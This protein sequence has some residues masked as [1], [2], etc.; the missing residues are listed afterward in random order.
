MNQNQARSLGASGIAG[1]LAVIIVWILS[2]VGIQVPADV[3]AAFLTVFA[4]LIGLYAHK[5]DPVAGDKP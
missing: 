4:S 2:I 5:A 1:A 3:S